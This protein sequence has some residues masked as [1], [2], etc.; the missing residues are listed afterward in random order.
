MSK[1]EWLEDLKVPNCHECPF[2][3]KTGNTWCWLDNSFPAEKMFGDELPEDC[4][5][6]GT[7]GCRVKPVGV[8]D[9][10]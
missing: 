1:K 10:L 2:G 3:H 4:P 8:S 6:N 7:H 5:M 9:A